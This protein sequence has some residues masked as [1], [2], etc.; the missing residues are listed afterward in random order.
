MRWPSHLFGV[1]GRIGRARYWLFL[2]AAVTLLAVLLVAFW[3]YALSI[4]GAYENG[5]PTPWPSTRLGIA[6]AVTWVSTLALV[7]ISIVANTIRRL[8]DRGKSGWWVVLFLIAP[9]ALFAF[10][11]YMAGVQPGDLPYG[12]HIAVLALM[13][14][15][16]VEL[17][18]LRGT[19]GDNRFGPDPLA[20]RA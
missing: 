3:I 20:A 5:G 19:I 17:C 1:N 9:N 2:A 10:A 16:F 13:A 7:L 11:Q 8:H 14:W 15:S 4:P 18:C 12:L 6:G